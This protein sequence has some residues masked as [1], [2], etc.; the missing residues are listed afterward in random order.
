MQ[1]ILTNPENACVAEI[2]QRALYN[3][4]EALGTLGDAAQACE[5]LFSL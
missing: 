5:C 4:G 2:L 3:D 1:A